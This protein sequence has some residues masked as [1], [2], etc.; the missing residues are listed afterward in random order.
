MA[1]SN[2]ISSAAAFSGFETRRFPILSASES[3]GDASLQ[4]DE[5]LVRKVDVEWLVGDNTKL[6]TQ[7][8][9]APRRG[10]E[11]IVRDL[12]NADS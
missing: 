4:R 12:R 3:T 7:T 2:V 10:V 9:W 6:R 8:G 5:S 11:D 1:P